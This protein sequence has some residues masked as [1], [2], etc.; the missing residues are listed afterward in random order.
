M[1]RTVESPIGKGIPAGEH[2]LELTDVA[3]E[4]RTDYGVVNAV[5]GISYTLDPGESLAILGE[6]GSGKTV[7]ALALMGLIEKPG[8][9]SRGRINYKGV[10]LLALSDQERRAIRGAEIAMIFQDALSALN[11]VF[12]VG[13]QIAEMFQ[14][15][16]GMSKREGMARALDL[17]ERV[18]IPSAKER[19]KDYPHQFSG[20]MRQRVMIA[21][22]ISLDPAILIADEP[23]TALDVTVQAQIMELLDELQKETK[24]GLILITHDLGVVAEV[25]NNVCVMYAGRIVEK[26]SAEEI[27]ASPSH[28]YTERLMHSIPRVDRK[29]QRLDP[30]KGAPPSLLNIPPGCAFHPRCPRAQLP[31]CSTE[32]PELRSMGGAR[33]SAC[34]FAEEVL[35]VNA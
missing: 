13:D 18:R 3:V 6:S 1:G 24:M 26:G 29:G 19:L 25:A 21:M 31:L 10:D 30:I 12:S 8:L 35:G 28:P 22:G 16:R 27:Y 4:F 15:H 23:S 14:V 33:M 34:H 7:S 5:N 11:P 2:L 17:M 20:G 9:V 32:S